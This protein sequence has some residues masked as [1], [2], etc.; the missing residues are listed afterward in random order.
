MAAVAITRD[1]EI[2][3]DRDLV[4]IV[5]HGELD[6]ATRVPLQ[7][8]L[9]ELR[10]AGFTRVCL[11][12]RPLQFC[13]GAGLAL[14]RRWRQLATIDGLDLRI[15]VADGP[16]TRAIEVSRLYAELTVTD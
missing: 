6:L 7:D 9:R 4:T 8:V 3:P 11:D 2:E 16:V 13:D 10:D 12:L 5:V 14:L 1:I 15:R